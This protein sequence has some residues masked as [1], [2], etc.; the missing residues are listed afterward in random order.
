MDRTR[1]PRCGSELSL[2]EM[3]G[4]FVACFDIPAGT[5]FIVGP[6]I[7]QFVPAE[8]REMR[9]AEGLVFEPGRLRLDVRGTSTQLTST[10]SRLLAHFATHPGITLSREAILN[11][12]WGDEYETRRRGVDTYVSRLRDHL[13]AYPDGDRMIVTV[14]DVGYRFDP[15]APNVHGI[16]QR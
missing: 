13:R 8:A 1:C 5:P 15:P 11:A 12:V 2:D 14:R 6:L 16:P 10:E 3:I 4:H 7:V 9:L